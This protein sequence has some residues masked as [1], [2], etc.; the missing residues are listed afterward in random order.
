LAQN[1]V[2]QPAGA[3][4]QRSETAFDVVG[5]FP[6]DRAVIRLIGA[7]LA[8]QHDEWAIARRYMSDTS[9]AELAETSAT[10]HQPQIEG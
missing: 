10:N 7:V 8:D 5:I 4:Q 3:A 1:L 6:N 2:E 9:M